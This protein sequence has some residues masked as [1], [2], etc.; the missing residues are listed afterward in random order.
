M[1]Q[2][3]APAHQGQNVAAVWKNAGTRKQLINI[4]FGVK[5]RGH[6]LRVCSTASA[7]S[8]YQQGL[9]SFSCIQ[10]HFSSQSVWK[11]PGG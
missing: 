10:E 7:E 8:S 9:T 11:T 6:P 5:G 3:S 4:Y 1:W 2:F